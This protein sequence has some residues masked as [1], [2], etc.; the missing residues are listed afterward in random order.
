MVIKV[1][2]A[3]VMTL[4]AAVVAEHLG[5]DQDEAL[6]MGRVVAG[7]NAYSKGRALGIYTPHPKTVKE[8]RKRLEGEA[9]LH[10]DLLRRAVPVVRT[11]TGLRA[12]SKDKPVTPESVQRYLVS[13]FKESLSDV[14]AA[15]DAL[16]ASLSPSD[17]ATRAYELYEQFR[18]AVP[19]GVKGW[20]AVGEFDLDKLRSLARAR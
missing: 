9:V 11:P 4:W 6:T 14:K 10:V 3:P 17:L 20:G 8:E 12:V 2:R 7:L 1:N 16:A 18:P 13:K 5:F 19:A 15:M